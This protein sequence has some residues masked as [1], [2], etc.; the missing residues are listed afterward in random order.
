VVTDTATNGVS[1]TV[2]KADPS[3]T[4]P[5]GLT[6]TVGD[7]LSTITL[8]GNGTSTPVGSFT[9]TAVGTTP[10]GASGSQTHNMT[11]TPT[12]TANYNTKTQDVQV[13]VSAATGFTVTFNSNG[14]S[15][16][17]PPATGIASGSAVGLPA[18][19]TKGTDIFGG[20]FKDNTTFNEPYYFSTAVTSSFTL[21]ARWI[22]IVPEMVTIPP[23]GPLSFTMGSGDSLDNA[24]S[25]AHT[26]TFANGFQMSKYEITHEQYRVVMLDNP[27]NFQ[28]G[29]VPLGLPGG[30]T[31]EHSLPVEQV[32]WYDAI[33]FCNRLSSSQSLTPVYQI[34]G[35]GNSDDPD[36]WI[37]Q[38]GGSIPTSNNATWNA[39]VMTGGAN[40]YRLPTEAEWEYACRAG[41]TTAFS[42]GN[43]D[44]TN[45]ALVNLVAWHS[46]NNTP[47]GTKPVG[48]KLANP[49]GLRDMHGNVYEWC[50][51]WLDTGYYAA[52]G[53]AGPDPQGGAG[54]YRVMRGGAWGSSAQGARSASRFSGNPGSRNYVVGFRVVRP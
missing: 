43:N 44:H 25:P 30:V 3:I 46:G 47:S 31:T 32:S 28:G 15:P 37:T 6:A 27:S 21:Y 53:A 1:F 36:Y 35:Y 12:D 52:P 26:V 8:P 41:T 2:I 5:T 14:G 17:P 24:A 51:D 42:D 48:T 20:W 38:A 29:S 45:N 54:T 4:W 10:V 18:S 39:V 23:S 11:F 13:V 9:W 19:P 22:S 50:W 16:T 40:G 34:P 7:T 49:W 33:V